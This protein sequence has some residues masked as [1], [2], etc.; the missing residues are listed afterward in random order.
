[1]KSI[2]ETLA[3]AKKADEQADAAFKKWFNGDSKT[4]SAAVRLQNR[5]DD[6]WVDVRFHPDYDEE[7]HG[8]MVQCNG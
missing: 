1:M 3:A 8:E 2:E 6:L 4:A 5:A 7:K